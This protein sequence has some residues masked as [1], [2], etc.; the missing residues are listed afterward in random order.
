M[1]GAGRAE[2]W[3]R[4]AGDSIPASGLEVGRACKAP[5]A[6]AGSGPE[7]QPCAAG[8]RAS[9]AGAGGAHQH[10][11][12]SAQRRRAAWC[13]KQAA[14]RPSRSAAH[15]VGRDA[16]ASQLGAVAGR[17]WSRGDEDLAAACNSRLEVGK[18]AAA[19]RLGVG[20]GD[21]V[22]HSRVVLAQL[23]A[24]EREGRCAHRSCAC[25]RRGAARMAAIS[26]WTGRSW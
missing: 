11:T 9:G 17:Q 18:L 13:A 22:G 24:V 20:E 10:A 2:G 8:R 23:H 5:T 4:C 1:R 12:P 21:R 6:Q 7:A 3:L 14:C 26:G 15:Q 25:D 16:R 19:A